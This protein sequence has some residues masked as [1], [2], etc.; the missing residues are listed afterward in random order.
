LLDGAVF[1]RVVRDDHEATGGLEL[2]DGAR[3][4][5]VQSTQLIVHL[6]PD[7]LERAPGRVPARSPRGCGDRIGHDSG[8]LESCAH[9]T[10]PDYRVCNPASEPLFPETAQNPGEVAFIVGV[11]DLF[12]RELGT[13]IHAHVEGAVSPEAEPSTSR[14]E[15]GGG[16]AKVE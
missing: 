15:L 7:R 5:P 14:V 11:H 2:V 13:R 9:R 8:E 12:R 6:D 4:H 3:Q 1:E 16:N 10:G